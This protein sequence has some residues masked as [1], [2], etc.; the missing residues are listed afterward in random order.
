MRGLST[1]AVGLWLAVFAGCDGTESPDGDGGASGGGLAAG[2]GGGGGG[3]ATGGTGGNATVACP[4]VAPASGSSCTASGQSCVYQDCAG[5]GVTVA[6]CQDTWSVTTTV[7]GDT[8]RC[9]YPSSQTCAAGQIC[10]V[11]A[12]GALYAQCVDNPCG[13]GPV[14]CGCLGVCSGVC[15]TLSSTSGVTVYCNTCPQ[16]G[17]A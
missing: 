5:A 3:R 2:G 13:T 9:P 6:S 17:C 14:E 7:C 4:P 8:V 11:Y 10:I 12:G 15:N 1:I 16:G